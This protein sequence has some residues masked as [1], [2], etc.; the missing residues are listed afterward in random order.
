MGYKE[1]TN[2]VGMTLSQLWYWYNYYDTGYDTL[3]SRA[4]LIFALDSTRTR[5]GRYYRE[6][7]ILSATI[8][9]IEGIF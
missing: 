7:T 5:V 3:V 4:W 6:W 8:I 9:D 1:G 2:K